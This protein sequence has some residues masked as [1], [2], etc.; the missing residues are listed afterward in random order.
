MSVRRGAVSS[1]RPDDEAVGAVAREVNLHLD[2]LLVLRI[3]ADGPRRAD[4]PK[5][6]SAAERIGLCAKSP[7]AIG[8]HGA[9]SRPA[10][11]PKRRP[12]SGPRRR[13]RAGRGGACGAVCGRLP[14][15]LAAD[16]TQARSVRRVATGSCHRL[17][18]ALNDRQDHGP[19]QR[20]TV[21]SA[22]QAA[23]S[24]TAG[25]SPRFV[26]CTNG[27]IGPEARRDRRASPAR[28]AVARRGPAV[29]VST[30]GVSRRGPCPARC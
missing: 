12:A 16:E 10:C 5:V 9:V 28:L 14:A 8:G 24:A 13:L 20:A 19:E 3:L 2:P 21:S 29:A 22:A 1:R 26:G 18:R 15:D 25:T 4:I 30:A 27:R 6:T 11:G 7:R 23:G 17:V